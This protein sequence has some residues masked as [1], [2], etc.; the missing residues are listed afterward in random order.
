MVAWSHACNRLPQPW[1]PSLVALEAL[2]KIWMQMQVLMHE[3]SPAIVRHGS[4]AGL[5]TIGCIVLRFLDESVLGLR[6]RRLECHPP[7]FLHFRGDPAAAAADS[8]DDDDGDE[9]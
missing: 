4:H 8:A 1:L 2:Q 7:L 9:I 3:R 5:G 6:L